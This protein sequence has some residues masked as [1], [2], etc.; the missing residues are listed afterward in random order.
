MKKIKSVLFLLAA[1]RKDANTKTLELSKER[2]QV[3]LT[4]INRSSD[5][6]SEVQLGEVRSTIRVCGKH[7]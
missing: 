4:K 1:V 2:K 7:K 3:R 6:L 5:N